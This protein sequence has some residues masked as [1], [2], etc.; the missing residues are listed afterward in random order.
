MGIL[1]HRLLIILN[2]ESLEST[3][4]HIAF[5]MLRY[6]RSLHE[7][8]IHKLAELC[9][10][11]KSTISKFIRFIG[12]EDFSDF[13]YAAIFEN[14]KYHF[15]FNYVVNVMGYMEQNS[16]DS[17]FMTISQD[18][19]MTYQNMDWAAVDQLVRDLAHYKTV[20]AFGL[21]FSE[22]AA[23]DFQIKLGYSGKIVVTNLNDQKQDQ[24][25]QNAGEDTLIIIFSDSGEYI[26]KY[27]MIDDFSNK[28]VFSRTKAKVVLITS[29]K[30]MKKD[31]RVAYGIYYEK[32][33]SMST[34]RIIY[35][36]LTDIIA[37]KYREYAARNGIGPEYER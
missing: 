12:Y 23:L 3:Y 16:M 7:I 21:M 31:P 26:N 28:Q 30:N 15:E 35:G 18:I 29:N 33:R 34:H 14:N 1:Y 6:I 9:D 10:V 37:Y 22:T 8:P 11:S 27:R 13:R 20:A 24:F 19:S 32:T 17:Y 2:E 4:Y 25:I 36:I 5:V